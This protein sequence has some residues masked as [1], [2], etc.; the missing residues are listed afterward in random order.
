[1]HTV[2]IRHEIILKLGIMHKVIPFTHD[3]SGFLLH[4]LTTHELNQ[5]PL[6][7]HI[8]HNMHNPKHG[9]IRIKMCQ[10]CLQWSAIDYGEC[11]R[12]KQNTQFNIHD[13]QQS[14]TYLIHTHFL[15]CRLEDLEVLNILMFQVSFELNPLHDHTTCNRNVKLS[16][17]KMCNNIHHLH[18]PFL[19][20]WDNLL[21]VIM[22]NIPAASR[23]TTYWHL[24]RNNLRFLHQLKKSFT[25][26]AELHKYSLS[27]SVCESKNHYFTTCDT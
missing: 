24:S 27:C 11:S 14:N 9:N 12:N 19:P 15:E 6:L 21:L 16:Q 8:H 1:M 22:S 18:S 5:K 20:V 2:L 10:N 7:A 4:L 3:V 13:E 25:C 26:Q 17:C 23:P